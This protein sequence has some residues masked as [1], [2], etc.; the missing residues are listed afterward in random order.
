MVVSLF[1][2]ESYYTFLDDTPAV[3]VI[4]L[5][6]YVGCYHGVGLLK[7]ILISPSPS[8]RLVIEEVDE[9][10]IGFPKSCDGKETQQSN[11]VR[12]GSPKENRCLRCHAHMLSCTHEHHQ[13]HCPVSLPYRLSTV[14]PPYQSVLVAP[15]LMRSSPITTTFSSTTKAAFNTCKLFGSSSMAEIVQQLSWLLVTTKHI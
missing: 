7:I 3:A 2:L 4:A 13:E 6:L 8:Q 12:N 15:P 10:I 9:S 11:K 5:L 1:V 14:T